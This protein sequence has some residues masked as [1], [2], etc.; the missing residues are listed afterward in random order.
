MVNLKKIT[1]EI[2]LLKA[3]IARQ[4]KL[5]D[6]LSTEVVDLKARSMRNNLLFHNFK[7]IQNENCEESVNMFLQ[8]GLRINAHEGLIIEACHRVGPPRSTNARPRPIVARFMSLKMKEYILDSQRMLTDQRNRRDQGTPYVTPQIPEERLEAKRSIVSQIYEIRKVTPITEAKVHLKQ[9]NIYINNDKLCSP[10][11]VPDFN[12]VFSSDNGNTDVVSKRGGKVEHN[13]LS[14]QANVY[15]TSSIQDVRTAYINTFSN[16]KT[17]SAAHNTLV[18]RVQETGRKY[19][20]KGWIDDGEHGTGRLVMQYLEEKGLNNVTAVITKQL[21]GR[22]ATVVKRSELI[23]K[24]VQEACDQ[25]I[26]NKKLIPTLKP[27]QQAENAQSTDTQTPST[28]GTARAQ[29]DIPEPAQHS[30]VSHSTPITNT[31][32]T[33]NNNNSQAGSFT[34]QQQRP[35]GPPARWGMPRQPPPAFWVGFND[36]RLPRTGWPRVNRQHRPVNPHVQRQSTTLHLAQSAHPPE[37]IDFSK[38][39]IY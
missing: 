26:A 30:P 9:D 25:L 39:E 2:D 8:N 3:I 21:R 22:M 31:P 34:H 38:D 37:L 36:H 14:V 23:N 27:T 20:S 32:A 35:R 6:A 24:S 10:L 11:K 19:V 5:I 16:P 33:R 13:G 29:N 7:E 18:Y 28:S 1:E 17:A 12:C 15:I 4:S